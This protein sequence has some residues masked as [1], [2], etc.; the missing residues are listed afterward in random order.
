MKKL[1]VF[2][3]GQ[4]YFGQEVFRLCNELPFVE[5]VGVCTPLDDKCMTKMAHTFNVP[6]VA[7]GTLRE[8]TLPDN[9]DL[10]IKIR[11][12]DNAAFSISNRWQH[13]FRI[14]FNF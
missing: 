7:G 8:D 14:R 10:G 4:K 1:R 5:I 13:Y 2:I 11:N 9:V 6:I 12:K 3:S